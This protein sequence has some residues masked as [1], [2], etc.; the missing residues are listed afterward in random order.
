MDMV[1]MVDM[2]MAAT[3]VIVVDMA[4]MVA[5]EAMVAMEVTME[6]MVDTVVDITKSINDV[7]SHQVGP[8]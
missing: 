7:P 4:V 3:E 2:D 8:L 1:D 6:V 5:M